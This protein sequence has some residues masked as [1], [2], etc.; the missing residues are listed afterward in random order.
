MY[1]YA[2]DEIFQ[3]ICFTSH[4]FKTASIASSRTSTINSTDITWH[5]ILFPVTSLQSM[6]Y[7]KRKLKLTEENI[8]GSYGVGMT[9]HSV[10]T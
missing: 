9:A 10:L 3:S 4:F 2:A 5:L 7:Q 8:P 1:F 6:Q